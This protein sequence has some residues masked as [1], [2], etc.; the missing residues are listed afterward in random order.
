MSP[1]IINTHA[2]DDSDGKLWG[3][4]G[5]NILFLLA[6]LLLSL[7]L[8]LMLFRQQV[9]RATFS[10]G[11]GSLPSCSLL[12]T[13]SRSGK[14]GRAPT[15]PIFWGS[16]SPAMRGCRRDVTR[17]IRFT[18]MKA[19][20]GWISHDLYIWN[21]LDRRGFVSK[22]FVLEIPDLRHGSEHALNSL[23]ES[24]RQFLRTLEESTRAQFRWAA[25][26]DHREELLSY[27][28][29]TDERC[30]PD[31]WV[32]ITRNERF[33]RSW[34]AMQSGRLRREKLV[35]FLSK[36]I[37]GNP[38]VS[39]DKQLLA[40]HYRRVLHQFNEAFEQYRH[41]IASL[42]EPHGC[43][44]TSMSTEDLFRYFAV[45]L[46]PCY[47]KRENYDP[48]RRL[49]PEETIHQNCWHQGVQARQTFGF[50]ADR[51]FHYLV[52]LKRRPRRTRRGLFWVLLG[53]AWDFERGSGKISGCGTPNFM[54]DCWD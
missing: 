14:A 37:T 13:S 27:K 33:N 30:E 11:V 15:I 17:A 51:Y 38:S 16:F 54:S 9:H 18:T 12:F 35:L 24:I 41:V 23:H 4:E 25:D 21:E 40:N 46:N 36:R 1:S 47:L 19:P 6:G 39:T 7:G 34:R 49:E 50:F 31:F 45:F 28:R 32:A 22:G 20:N 3:I 43:R 10:F 26:A 52:I 29:I 2:G 53:I 48:I 44:V 8:S 5:I 42:F